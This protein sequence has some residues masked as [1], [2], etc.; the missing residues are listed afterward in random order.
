MEPGIWFPVLFFKKQNPGSDSGS[1]SKNQ[2]Q[3]SSGPKTDD[4]LPVNLSFILGSS[5]F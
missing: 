1:S 2:T 3:F 4:E 5:I